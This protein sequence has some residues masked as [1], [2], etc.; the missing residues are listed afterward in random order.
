MIR[1]VLRRQ[2]R[3]PKKLVPGAERGRLY[4][5]QVPSEPSAAAFA[6]GVATITARV[7][8]AETDTWEDVGILVDDIPADQLPPELLQEI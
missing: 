2:K 7:Y 4:A 5:P 3:K 8:R 6:H 1:S